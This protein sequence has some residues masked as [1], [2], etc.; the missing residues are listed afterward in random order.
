MR[1]HLVAGRFD[2]VGDPGRS[3]GHAQAYGIDEARSAQVIRDERS[4][5]PL[6]PGLRFGH[7]APKR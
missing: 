3:G 1:R 2:E 4:K 6:L 7:R 5:G